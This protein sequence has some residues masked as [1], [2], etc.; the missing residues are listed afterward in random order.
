MRTHLASPMEAC[1][2]PCQTAPCHLTSLLEPIIVVDE[3]QKG[4]GMSGEGGFSHSLPFKRKGDFHMV[5]PC[6]SNGGMPQGLI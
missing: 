5:L 3:F 4:R 2:G 6:S 1:S